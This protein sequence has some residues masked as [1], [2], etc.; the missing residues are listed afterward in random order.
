[1]KYIKGKS[2]S[3]YDQHSSRWD[4]SEQDF[5]RF[6]KGVLKESSNHC[7]KSSNSTQFKEFYMLCNQQFLDA[8]TLNRGYLT[9]PEFYK[10]VAVA[11]TIPQRFGYYDWY[12]NARFSVVAT[13][14]KVRWH[15]WFKF[16]LDQ[17]REGMSKLE[18]NKIVM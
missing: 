11:A 15:Q 2:D 16:N 9:E 4:R 10:L 6:F 12:L 8:A 3:L 1:M 7:H 13:D 17:I 14:D 18:Q 5:L